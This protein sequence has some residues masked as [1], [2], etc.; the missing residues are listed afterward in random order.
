MKDYNKLIARAEGKAYNAIDALMV[1]GQE[2]LDLTEYSKDYTPSYTTDG[3]T[4]VGK[5]NP[6]EEI[7]Y[8]IVIEDA[9]KG[10]K[11]K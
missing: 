8:Q 5:G 1:L 4:F 10:G 9:I 6:L 3:L 2:V 11:K 7:P